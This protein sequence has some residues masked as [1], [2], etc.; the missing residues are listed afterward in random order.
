MLEIA[1]TW[2]S[3]LSTR[4][5]MDPRYDF[6]AAAYQH[7]AGIIDDEEAARLVRVYVQLLLVLLVLLVVW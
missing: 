3:S 7:S 2:E 1:S 6:I 5:M 4:M